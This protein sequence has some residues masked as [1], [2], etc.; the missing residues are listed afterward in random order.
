MPLDKFPHV[1][2][3]YLLTDFDPR[4]VDRWLFL[5]PLIRNYCLIPAT[6]LSTGSDWN[7]QCEEMQAILIIVDQALGNKIPGIK[8]VLTC[9]NRQTGAVY[10]RP[11]FCF[12]GR[13]VVGSRVVFFVLI[14]DQQSS[15]KLLILCGT[16]ASNNN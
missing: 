16:M 2:C 7:Q 1:F 8:S 5:H 14:V 10:V 12:L 9:I 15:I 11:I 3:S 4:L 6:I 13:T